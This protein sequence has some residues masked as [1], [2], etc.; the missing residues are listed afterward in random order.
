MTDPLA[1][2]VRNLVAGLP[3]ADAA[4]LLRAVAAQL[5][6]GP[7]APHLRDAAEHEAARLRTEG[8]TV[9]AG[10]TIRTA[11]AAVVG[12]SPGTLRNWRSAGTG[13]EWRSDGPI[14]VYELLRLLA[15][16]QGVILRHEH[17]AANLSA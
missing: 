11:A 5:D 15:W 12:R 9:G 7:A 3:R 4:R 2:R 8:F 16:R 10:L 13:P 17:H 6:H 14:V 1:I